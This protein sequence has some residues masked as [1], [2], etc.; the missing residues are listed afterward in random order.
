MIIGPYEEPF[1]KA[2]LA[3]CY[4]LCDEFILVDTAPGNNPN[5]QLMEEFQ[6]T[7]ID[8]FIYG[9]PIKPVKIIDMPRGEDKDFNFGE[10]RE[11]ARLA[12]THEWIFRMDADEVLHEK[13]IPKLLKAVADCNGTNYSSIEISFYHFMVYPWLYQYIEPRIAFFKKDDAYWK[14][15]VAVH[16]TLVVSG[17][18]KKT[19][20][21]YYHYGYCRGQEEVFKRWQLYKDIEGYP[22]WYAGQNPATIIEDRIV[23][24]K[25]FLGEH[26]TV[27]QPVLEQMFSGVPPFQN[28]GD[29]EV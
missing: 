28:S 8:S 14:Q 12:S 17:R 11:L 7:Q 26:P 18:V 10:A 21:L 20:I 15:D 4:Q 24:C 9:E 13:D 27:V 19:D 1:L 2:S 29:T 23:V 3:S 25:N 5:R 22:T 6:E 16:E